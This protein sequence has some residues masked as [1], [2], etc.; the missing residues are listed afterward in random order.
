VIRSLAVTAD[1]LQRIV[2][3]FSAGAASA[4]T[5]KLVLAQYPNAEIIVARCLVPEEHEDND[6]F[7]ADC[8]AWFGRPI[9]ELRSAEYASC[10]DVWE[11]TRYMS[12]IGGARCTVEMKKA[13]RQQFE[14]DWMP[15]LQAFGYTV[16]ERGRVDRFR[17]QNPEVRLLTP[18]IDEG[19]TKDDCFAIIQRAGLLLPL[20]YRLGWPN[21][22]C[23][24]CVNDQSPKGWNRVRR[25]FPEVFWRRNKMARALGVRL[26]K[27]ST[28]DRERRYLDELDPN[29]MSDDGAPTSDCSLLC[30]IAES[31]LREPAA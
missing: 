2:V 17:A 30:A 23:I 1:R 19:L 20:L 10:E 29:D 12:G 25:Y 27:L 9:L 21:A 26:V 7:A 8:S 14:R 4:V 24:G 18:L 3:W 31:K 22:N 13:V 15:D 28:G 6:R 11:R 16:E 5:V